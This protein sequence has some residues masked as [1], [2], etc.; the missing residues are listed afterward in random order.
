MT[1]LHL[2]W[3]PHL[4]GYE[5]I[6][7]K[8]QDLA[9]GAATGGIDLDVRIL[10]HDAGPGP[11]MVPIRSVV[12]GRVRKLAA[13]AASLDLTRYEA[14]VLR[15]PGAIDF[16]L[17][18]FLRQHAAR[19]IT[20]HHTDEL[21]ELR[22]LPVGWL[23]VGWEQTM[24]SQFLGRV[25]GAVAVTRE[26]A[27]RLRERGLTAPTAVIANGIA[28]QEIPWLPPKAWDGV[29]PLRL[30]FA[31]GFFWPWQGLDRLLA[32]ILLAPPGVVQ[33]HLAGQVVR[34]I[35]RA[36]WERCQR[37]RPGQVVAHGP[38]SRAELAAVA[39]EVHG[40]VSTLAL[41]RKG[42]T[43]ACPI[44]SR[45]YLARGLPL[46][47]AYRDP[48]VP[49]ELPGI[50]TVPAAEDPVDILALGSAWRRWSVTWGPVTAGLRAHAETYL[51]HRAKA[52]A[53][54]DFARSC[55]RL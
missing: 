2:T 41:H 23:R 11:L 46:V 18:G 45:E 12:L 53:L 47:A 49:A 36:L 39:Q 14:I 1:I 52:A 50:L 4:S 25:A 9:R 27:D 28:V 22:D 17:P 19:L 20:E 29:G 10:S 30:L 43:E 31:S 16:S 24:G 34:P 54:V 5:G 51:D 6:L 7:H 48:D 15:Y 42:M 21:A 3:L 40:A 37:E 8:Q 55:V 44:K 33:V 13:M 32:G 38:M 35:D 26:L